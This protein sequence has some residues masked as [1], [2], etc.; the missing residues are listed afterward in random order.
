[1]IR[2]KQLRVENFKSLR[3]V[4]IAFPDVGSILIEGLNESGKSTLFESVY[5]ALY[6]RPLIAE[7]GVESTIRYGTQEAFVELAVTVDATQLVVQRRARRG[8]NPTAQLTISHPGAADEVLTRVRPINQRIVGE[9]GGLDGDTLLNSCFVEQKKLQRLEGLDAASRRASL[10]RLLNLESLTDLE[11][12]FRVS[13]LDDDAIQS[14]RGRRDLARVRTEIPQHELELAH[15]DRRLA[16]R[17]ILSALAQIQGAESEV[18]T[19]KNRTAALEERRAS[20]DARLARVEAVRQTHQKANE[21]QQISERGARE[22]EAEQAVILERD[23]LVQLRDERL[24]ATVERQ[25]AIEQLTCQLDDIEHAEA[26]AA[27]LT[28]AKAAC[29]R[30]VAA[31]Q[32]SAEADGQAGELAVQ[33]R[34]AAAVQEAR[35]SVEILKQLREQ[36]IEHKRREDELAARVAEVEALA[37]VRL[38]AQQARLL[39]LRDV[40]AELATGMANVEAATRTEEG[41]RAKIAALEMCAT[42]L[43][44]RTAADRVAA[45]AQEAL[46]RAQETLQAVR[47]AQKPALGPVLNAWISARSDADEGE[48]ATQEE[49]QAAKAT[50]EATAAIER[51]QADLA[52]ATARVLVILGGGLG[53]LVVGAFIAIALGPRL[54]AIVILAAIAIL[55][56]DIVAFRT[57]SDRTR[58]LLGTREFLRAAERRSSE[59]RATTAV[60]AHRSPSSRLVEAERALQAMGE[61][62]P[63]DLATAV[64]RAVEVRQGDAESER[65]VQQENEAETTVQLCSRA[66]TDAQVGL[67]TAADAYQVAEN[68]VRESD[69]FGMDMEAARVQL[70]DAQTRSR[71][72]A[73]HGTRAQDRADRLM[74]AA[75]PQLLNLEAAAL[76]RSIEEGQGQ[77]NLLPD[78]QAS[79]EEAERRTITSSHAV[80]DRWSALS[81][82]R[83]AL[84]FGGRGRDEDIAWIEAELA[85]LARALDEAGLREEHTRLLRAAE[86][87]RTR[88]AGLREVLQEAIHRARRGAEYLESRGALPTVSEMLTRFAAVAP[89]GGPTDLAGLSDATDLARRKLEGMAQRYQV[90]LNLRDLQQVAADLLAEQR[91]MEGRVARLRE[92]EERLATATD[93]RV[94][95]EAELVAQH[96]VLLSQLSTLGLACD[97]EQLNEVTRLLASELRELDEPGT[98]AERDEITGELAGIQTHRRHLN[99]QITGQWQVIRSE[100]AGVRVLVPSCDREAI[101]G[102]LPEVSD[103]RLPTEDELVAERADVVL[104]IRQLNA[105]G[106]DLEGSLGLSSVE[107]DLQ[108]TEAELER[109]VRD[110]EVKRRATTIISMARSRMVSRVLPSTEQNLRLLLPQLTAQRYFDAQLGEDYRLNVW[111]A[112]AGRYVAKDIFSGGTKDQFSLALRLAFALATLPQELGTTPGFMFLDEPLSSFDLPRTTALVE[113]ITRGQIAENFAQI[114]LIS[115]SQ[116]FDSDI[117]SYY[118]RLSDGQISE[119]NLQRLPAAS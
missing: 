94:E 106:R 34:Q 57:R 1:M 17:R 83:T 11:S 69:A 55:G 12:R 32:E 79:L 40:A 86:S 118:I 68:A 38:P 114:I 73:T 87:A 84:G 90:P 37:Q 62:T 41:A 80:A 97:R 70:A 115:H 77:A 3:D 14:A 112:G 21:I 91:H 85:E 8:R 103:P 104:R 56:S 67:R 65:L 33:L 7:G 81:A 59:A 19:D 53:V 74:P 25:M 18:E 100:L 27:A 10:L 61:P 43:S 113:L 117:F 71:E 22:W 99:E 98:R 107:L 58:M 76:Q 4:A 82:Q 20:L 28:D 45:D 60:L 108:E 66:H 49:N 95:T 48:S 64:Q 52:R 15:L 24:P 88:A 16:A 30:A 72:A 13:R 92:I 93:K 89:Y 102:A 109:A 29:A 63:N 5:F 26:S 111:D 2:L 54:G 101:T 96:A 31:E 105:Q 36:S 9:L 116:S 47:A 119:T 6:G 51:A 78:L 46:Q 50:D 75:T 35:Q 39:E 44:D 23:E 42:A 110:R